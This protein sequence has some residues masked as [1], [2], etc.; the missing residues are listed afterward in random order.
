MWSARNRTEAVTC[1]A[2]G[3]EVSRSRAREYDKHGDRWNR[4]DKTFE[5]L[6]KRCDDELCRHPRDELEELLVELEAGTDGTS[7]FLTAYFRAV[8]ERYGSL[9]ER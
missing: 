9:E 8:E 4:A 3:D 6:C 1:L 2:C 5:H 7:R